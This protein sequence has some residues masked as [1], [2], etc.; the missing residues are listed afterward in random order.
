MPTA[1]EPRGPQRGDA[2]VY[3]TPSRMSGGGACA[4]SARN[5]ESPGRQR[6]SRRS[7]TTPQAP[8]A[9][10]DDR[11]GPG[12]RLGP[13]SGGSVNG[14]RSDMARIALRSTSESAARRAGC[15]SP[16]AR[17]AP[18]GWAEADFLLS[19]D[20]RCRSGNVRPA[21]CATAL[22]ATLLLCGGH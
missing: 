19:P 12:G 8:A 5:S 21:T 11:H 2:S 17:A 14:A 18:R 22:G 6:V 13:L 4:C 16:P 7:R 3:S 9:L 1:A 15:P 10:A 20:A